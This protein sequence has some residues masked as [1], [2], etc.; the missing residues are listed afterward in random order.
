LCLKILGDARYHALQTKCDEDLAERTRAA[1]CT[2]CGG[3]LDSAAYPRKPRGATSPLSSEDERRFSFCCAV[4]G[5]RKRHTPPSVRFLGR[6]VYLGAVVILATAMQQGVTPVRARRLRE[7][8]G[9]SLRTLARW[10]AWWRT[11]FAESAFW[12]AARAFVSPAVDAANAPLALLERFGVD[13]ER[14][15]LALLRFL[16]PLST[17]AGY[18]PDQRF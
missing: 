10:R 8:L 7:L 4:E 15:L 1:G 14:R 11:T 6:R 13:E 9:V 3:R 5:C 18:L 12:K 17:P 2:E 16:A